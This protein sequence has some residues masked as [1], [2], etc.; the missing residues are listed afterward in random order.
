ME[1]VNCPLC[2]PKMP[3]SV[4]ALPSFKSL[5]DRWS[6]AANVAPRHSLTVAFP[7]RI[8][9]RWNPS[10]CIAPRAFTLALLPSPALSIDGH[11]SSTESGIERTVNQRSQRAPLAFPLHRVA[12]LAAIVSHIVDR[13]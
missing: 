4:V 10:T 6:L 8:V 11:S 7:R 12:S 2:L 13:W 1:C 3:E 9:D 5:V